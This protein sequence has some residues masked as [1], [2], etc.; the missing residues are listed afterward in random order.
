MNRLI[1][2]WV[3]AGFGLVKAIDACADGMVVDKVYHPYVLPNERELEW[4]LISRD[5]NGENV[6][7]QRLGFGHAI[8]ETISVEGYLN[9]ERDDEGDFGLQSYE[10]E[11]RWMLTDQGR[12]WADWGM[13]FELEREHQSDNWETSAAVLVEKE[14]GRTS[15]TMNLFAIYE[16]GEDLKDEWET[17]FRLQYRYRWLPQIQPSIEIYAGEDFAGVGPGFMG[18]QRYSGQRQLKWEA[19][20]ITEVSK[21]GT[22]N[23]F[24]LALE[25]EF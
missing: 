20:F 3:L 10:I 25:F 5:K 21:S 9:G 12:Y 2:L 23:T 16:W 7:A 4:R 15:L 6:L 1:L 13:L 8:S 19:G 22:D 14:I 24:R 17:E 11:A 18:I